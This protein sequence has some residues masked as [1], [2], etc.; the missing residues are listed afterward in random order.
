[1]LDEIVGRLPGDSD[2]SSKRPA[3]GTSTGSTAKRSKPSAGRGR[4]RGRGRGGDAAAG[5]EGAREVSIFQDPSWAGE[6][7]I[8][9]LI[10]DSSTEFESPRAEALPFA[11][12]YPEVEVRC[13]RA[14]PYTLGCALV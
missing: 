1:M 8:T 3:S 4:G 12:A 14:G 9:E 13:S 2:S 7:G 6:D 5:G 10:A 11:E